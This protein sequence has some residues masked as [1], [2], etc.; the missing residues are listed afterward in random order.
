MTQRVPSEPAR[1]PGAGR[2]SA[3]QQEAGGRPPG[4]A[5]LDARGRG[6]R[7]GRGRGG[8]G[9]EIQRAGRNWTLKGCAFFLMNEKYTPVSLKP[10]FCFLIILLL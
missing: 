7:R 8:R 6:R 3:A 4:G 10:L 2:W 9:A 1:P 5:G